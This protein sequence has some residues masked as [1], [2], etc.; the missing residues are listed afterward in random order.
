MSQQT[1]QTLDAFFPQEIIHIVKAQDF[2][3]V[4]EQE[5]PII[6]LMGDPTEEKYFSAEAVKRKIGA[7]QWRDLSSK[8]VS[9]MVSPE[10]VIEDFDSIS[11][12]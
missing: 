6:T 4:L 11:N 7:S 5:L 1:F 8:Y 9:F 2:V 12:F 10:I 3:G